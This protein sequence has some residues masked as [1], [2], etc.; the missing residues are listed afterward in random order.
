ML[1]VVFWHHHRQVVHWNHIHWLMG[2]LLRNLENESR[3]TVH[4][5]S[6]FRQNSTS[7]H[8]QF[9]GGEAGRSSSELKLRFWIGLYDSNSTA[10]FALEYF[11][12]DEDSEYL[13]A[14]CCDLDCSPSG[15]RRHVESQ[16]NR[17]K[18]VELP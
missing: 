18:I 5:G 12:K 9:Q 6:A 3:D 4:H 11:I 1:S 17:A 7:R 2:L 8:G 16:R 13:Y 15:N 10:T 14:S